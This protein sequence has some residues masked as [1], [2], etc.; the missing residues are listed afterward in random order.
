MSTIHFHYKTTSTPEQFVAGLTDFGPGRSTLFGNSADAYLKVHHRSHSEADVTEGS[1]GIWE[2]LHY[3]WSDPDRV[4]MTTI[5]SNVWGGRSGHTYTFTRLPNGTT[6]LDAV[7][8]REGKNIKG[9]VLGLVLGSIG[10]PVLGKTFA[11]SIRAIEAR[12]GVAREDS[13]SCA[14]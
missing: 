13:A 2:R 9:R 5:D 11:N 4:V 1:G 3:D 7:V 10:R 6:A 14:S 12:S 8:V